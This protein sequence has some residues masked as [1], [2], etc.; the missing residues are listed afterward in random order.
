VV[1]TEVVVV[2][3]EEHET[4]SEA[5]VVALELELLWAVVVEDCCV[6]EEDC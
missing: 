5:L 1:C 2:S 4:V 6:V 3:V